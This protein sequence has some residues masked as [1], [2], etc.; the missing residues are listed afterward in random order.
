MAISY[1]IVRW[2]S[3]FEPL[4]ADFS[5]RKRLDSALSELWRQIYEMLG[6]NGLLDQP[7][8][9]RLSKEFDLYAD[10]LREDGLQPGHFRSDKFYLSE[11]EKGHAAFVEFRQSRLGA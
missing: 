11:T 4:S 10:K 5:E 3:Q 2:R 1:Q 9:Q 6:A 7:C 8:A